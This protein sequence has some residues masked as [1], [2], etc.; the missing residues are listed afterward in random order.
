MASLKTLATFNMDLLKAKIFLDKINRE[1][2]R[3]SKDP[4][5]IVRIDV[6]IMQAYIR[7]LY[8][9][10]LSEKPVLAAVP[11]KQE[12]AAA[13]RKPIA[14]RPSEPAEAQAPSEP[15]A[16]APAPPREPIAPPV[17][18]EKPAPAPPPP[19]PPVIEPVA[20]QAPVTKPSQAHSPA[21]PEAEALF[22][23]KEHREL[24][25]KLS[26]LPIADLKRAIAL[27]DRL[28]LTRELF[29]GDSNAFEAALSALNSFSGFEQAKMYLLENC[30]QRFA[31]TD[32]KRLDAAKHF[33][34][35]VRRRYK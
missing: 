29:G 8:D 2:A 30:V 26:D 10:F 13:H 35:L 7:D 28:L 17:L 20:E 16:P 33:I 11:P 1:F 31:W 5:N 21:P 9:A 32:K 4:D 12:P 6:D 27:N 24:S 25:D 23:Q 19:P 3:M 34:K 22:E 14:T 15:N 18:E